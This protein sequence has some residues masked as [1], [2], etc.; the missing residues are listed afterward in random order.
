MSQYEL[1]LTSGATVIPFAA[2]VIRNKPIRV[3]VCD[4]T[5]KKVINNVFTEEEKTMSVIDM[6]LH[7]KKSQLSAKQIVELK[8]ARRRQKNCGYSKKAR[9]RRKMLLINQREL[10]KEVVKEIGKDSDSFPELYDI[11]NLLEVV[12]I[13]KITF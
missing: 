11:P 12:R 3:F 7:V 8:L 5:V 2:P 9:L 10:G 6:H 13:I 4:G 1:H